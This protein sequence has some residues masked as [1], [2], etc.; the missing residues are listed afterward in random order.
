ML[1]DYRDPAVLRRLYWDEGLTIGQI[2]DRCMVSKSAIH[3]WMKKAGIKGRSHKE[4]GIG[5]N[6]KHYVVDG[7][8]LTVLE[9]SA[10]TGIPVT[11]LHSR[12]AR[13]L[14][15]IPGELTRPP[16]KAKLHR[17]GDEL[18]TARQIA[19]R[20]GLPEVTIHGRVAHGWADEELTLPQ[21]PKGRGGRKRRW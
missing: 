15:N 1:E 9:I 21:Q 4:R 8:A 20:T 10:R 14:D 2:A 19:E 11:T 5:A 7:E 12:I 18:L 17:I 16:Q 3:L 13:G 6:A